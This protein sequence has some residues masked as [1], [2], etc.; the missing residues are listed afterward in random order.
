MR[1]DASSENVRKNLRGFAPFFI[2]W[3]AP[4]LVVYS[5][6]FSL[7]LADC[8]NLPLIIGALIGFLLAPV[9]YFMGVFIVLVGEVIAAR[10]VV[11]PI[12]ASIVNL[13]DRTFFAS[14]F[15]PV[16]TSPPRRCLADREAIQPQ[17]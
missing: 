6:L 13:A 8:M 15:L 3:V 2:Q 9:A 17:G 1:F 10:Q 16:P 5:F 11:C 7:A 4:A 12:V 14:A